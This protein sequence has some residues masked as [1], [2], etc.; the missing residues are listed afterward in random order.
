MQEPQKQ[1]K[2][3]IVGMAPGSREEAPYNDPTWEIWSLA[4]LVQVG[5]APRFTRHFEL[6][7]L[8]WF[9]DKPETR[10][11]WDWL[12]SIKD[13]QVYLQE[14]APE[15]PAGVLFPKSA[16]VQAFG[17]YFTNTVSWMIALAI[18]EEPAEIG[19]WGVDMA[20]NTEYAHQR[21]SC[22]YFMGIA[23][24]RGI[25]LHV[26]DTSDLLK[27]NKLYGFDHTDN[28]MSIKLKS[29]IEELGVRI[30]NQEAKQ[31]EH[32][33]NM[34]A[35]RGARDFA[36]EYLTQWLQDWGS[37]GTASSN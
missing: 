2:I 26:P 31:Q 6:H 19:V 4:T 14:T 21:P 29:K 20:Q 23:V 1:K 8:D 30:H 35:L 22:E 33:Q 3:A 16:I 11:Y 13:Q 5:H 28:A 10:D 7:P 18:A 12:C 32:L 34:I 24:G 15:I 37:D 17:T 25:K 27:T 36:Q 9:R